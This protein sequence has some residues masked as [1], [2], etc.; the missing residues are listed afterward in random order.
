MGYEVVGYDYKGFGRS[1]GKKG[2]I[3]SPEQFI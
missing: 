1:D 2:L 3:D